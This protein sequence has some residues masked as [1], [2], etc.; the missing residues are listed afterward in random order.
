VIITKVTGGRNIVENISQ[1]ATDIWNTIKSTVSQLNPFTPAAVVQ[2]PPPPSAAGAQPE[3]TKPVEESV[4]VRRQQPVEFTQI[5][6]KEK[7]EL[8]KKELQKIMD[9]LLEQ[10]D[11]IQA[12]IARLT[13][14]KKVQEVSKEE[15]EK[16]KDEE[17]EKLNEEDEEL[18]K[19]QAQITICQKSRVIFPKGIK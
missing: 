15:L 17:E 11:L 18:Q 12:E 13:K 1:I 2:P 4:D 8:K 9:D 16:E 19:A 7:E 6:E 10:I 3:E 14:K 5:S